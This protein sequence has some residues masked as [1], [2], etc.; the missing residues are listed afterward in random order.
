MIV[1]AHTHIYEHPE[2]FP[3]RPAGTADLLREMDAAGVELAVVIPLPG[4]ATN[5]YVRRECGL[6]P[7]RLIPFYTPEFDRPDHT[8]A[9]LSR[10]FEH[11]PPHGVKIHPR[12]QQV[13]FGQP[14]V[15]E[16]T[17]WIAERGIPLLIDCFPAGD[18]YCDARLHPAAYHDVARRFPDLAIILAHAGGYKTIEAFMTAKAHPNVRLETSFTL[19]YFPG[20]SI[21]RDLAFAVRHFFPGK[22][23]YGSDF[24]QYGIGEYLR[25]TR[26]AIDG[27]SSE[28]TASFYGDA[29]CSLYRVGEFAC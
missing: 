1:D 22:T 25:N 2:Q 16:T 28:Q 4:V 29:A 26:R 6:H 23:L 8:I 7:D 27:L 10:H 11:A 19:S 14:L 21:E 13:H 24:P 3:K 9:A 20:T 17:A 18:A 12:L 15:Q 5:E